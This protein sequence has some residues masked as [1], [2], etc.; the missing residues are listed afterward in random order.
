MRKYRATEA[1]KQASRAASRRWRKRNPEKVKYYDGEYKKQWRART[2]FYVPA[3]V[4]EARRA[5]KAL[6]KALAAAGGY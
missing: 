3:E 2:H 1:G 5:L 6:E 4:H